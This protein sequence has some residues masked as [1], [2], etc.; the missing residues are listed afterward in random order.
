MNFRLQ[1]HISYKWVQC[2]TI[3]VRSK[4]D[5]LADES[6]F[7]ITMSLS[8]WRSLFLLLVYQSR[9]VSG[10][11]IM[12][13]E[14]VLCA[15]QFQIVNHWN[16]YFNPMFM[17]SIYLNVE[18]TTIC[19]FLTNIYTGSNRLVNGF[20]YI[21]SLFPMHKETDHINSI[22]TLILCLWISSNVDII[23]SGRLTWLQ[24]TCVIWNAIFKMK[25]ISLL[26]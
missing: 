23:S 1:L 6:N 3:H 9:I 15:D 20:F 19:G 7:H 16:L 25:L 18:F 11:F 12:I 10:L 8:L 4:L 24:A 13:E 14:N 17:N 2:K 22:H 21:P 26:V 5:Q